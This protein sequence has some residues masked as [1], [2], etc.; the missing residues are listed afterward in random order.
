MF[1]STTMCFL[2]LLKEEATWGM[3]FSQKTTGKQRGKQ[4]HVMLLGA[5]AGSGY[6]FLA[7]SIGQSN[8]ITKPNINEVGKYTL[9]TIIY[10]YDTK[11][12]T[13]II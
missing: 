1:S 11:F 3:F 2:V 7:L 10:D 5:L 8:H 4:K 12:K 6:Y 13:Y 9:T